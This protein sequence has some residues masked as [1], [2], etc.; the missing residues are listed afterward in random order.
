[1]LLALL[2]ASAQLPLSA[3]ALVT[4]NEATGISGT[5]NN[6]SV[7]WSF[8]VTNAITLNALGWYDQGQDGLSVAHT[9]GIWNSGGT[10]LASVVVPAGTTG[11]LIG[12]YRTAS[13][14]SVILSP[15][16]GYVVGGENFSTST[17][18]LALSVTQSVD[19]NIVF[20]DARFGPQG[21]GFVLPNSVAAGITG[22]YGPMA[23]TGSAAVPEPATFGVACLG[24]LVLGWAKSR[25]R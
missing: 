24:L 23:F 11:P 21:S 5:Q 2:T 8:N 25:R 3:A 15:G 14:T 20:V 16:N 18:R 13:I 7:G 19:P 6:Q 9:V 1:M 22:F 4:F 12:V 17:D 10:L